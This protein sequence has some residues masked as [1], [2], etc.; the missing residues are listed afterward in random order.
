MSLLLCETGIFWCIHNLCY[1]E[2]L[3]YNILTF[4]NKNYAW[5]EDFLNLDNN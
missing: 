2:I 5:K 3:D 1:S 4:R